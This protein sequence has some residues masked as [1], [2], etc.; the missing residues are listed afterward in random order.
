VPTAGIAGGG[1]SREWRGQLRAGAVV[2]EAMAAVSGRGRFEMRQR[3][4]EKRS[5][6]GFEAQVYSL[7]NRRI[8]LGRATWAMSHIF[9]G[10]R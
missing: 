10:Y 8:Y 2:A 5:A 6:G 4:E 9:I 3:R 1:A 7:I